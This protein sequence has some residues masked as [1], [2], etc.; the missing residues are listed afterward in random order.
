MNLSTFLYMK[1]KDNRLIIA[2]VG[3]LISLATTIPNK[4]DFNIQGVPAKMV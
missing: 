3:A 4:N 1:M 2:S